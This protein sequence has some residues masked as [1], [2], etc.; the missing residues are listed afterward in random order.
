MQKHNK[1][2]LNYSKCKFNNDI[3]EVYN[4]INLTYFKLMMC[5]INTI[6]KIPIL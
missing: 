4:N 3:I 2:I 5:I 6:F 1:V